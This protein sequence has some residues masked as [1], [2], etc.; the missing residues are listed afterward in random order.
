MSHTTS[1]VRFV[2]LNFANAMIDIRFDIVQGFHQFNDFVIPS[3]RFAH[4]GAVEFVQFLSNNGY[5]VCPLKSD[6]S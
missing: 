1:L 5:L 4:D 6:P 3:I 2:V